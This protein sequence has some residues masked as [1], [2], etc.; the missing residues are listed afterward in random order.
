MSVYAENIPGTVIYIRY[1]NQTEV[2]SVDLSVTVGS[3]KETVGQQKG[4]LPSSLRFIFGG[5][6]LDDSK[7]LSEYGLE[8]ESTIHVVARGGGRGSKRSSKSRKSRGRSRGR[9]SRR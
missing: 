9:S 3:F 7:T 1:N 4:I 8:D 2:Y 5:K 6:L